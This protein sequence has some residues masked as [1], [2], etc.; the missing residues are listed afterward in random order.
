MAL[1]SNNMQ[2][3]SINRIACKSFGFWYWT[4]FL[5]YEIRLFELFHLKFKFN[6]DCLNIAAQRHF[7]EHTI[8]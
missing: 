3:V 4:C 8:Q 2:P 7:S 5:L 6:T 1:K